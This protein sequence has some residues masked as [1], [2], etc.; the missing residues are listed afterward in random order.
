[1]SSANSGRLLKPRLD[2]RMPAEHSQ[3]ECGL[4]KGCDK[5]YVPAV[6]LAAK[7]PQDLDRLVIPREGGPRIAGAKRVSQSPRCQRM[8]VPDLALVWIQSHQ[9]TAKTQ[10]FLEVF[11]RCFRLPQARA[12]RIAEIACDC[13]MSVGDVHLYLVVIGITC[14]NLLKYRQRLLEHLHSTRQ[15]AS[16]PKQAAI[17]AVRIRKVSPGGDGLIPF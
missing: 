4:G 16:C 5:R 6:P 1:M 11:H 9:P 3:R 8:V 17:R 7:R 10:A 15:V 14:S 2:L 12:V 13:R